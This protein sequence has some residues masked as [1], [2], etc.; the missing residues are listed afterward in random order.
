MIKELFRKKTKSDKEKLYDIIKYSIKKLIE[1]ES[2]PAGKINFLF[3][4]FTTAIVILL[5][6]PNTFLIIMSSL[7][8]RIKPVMPWYAMLTF[9]GLTVLYF[10]L[11][12]SKLMKIDENKR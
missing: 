2:S 1:I 5:C 12:A 6:V 11:C 7:F 8:P 3:G 10:Y 9:F 4:V